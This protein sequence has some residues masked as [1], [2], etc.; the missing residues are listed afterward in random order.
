MQQ[1]HSF[2]FNKGDEE[3]SA[4][5]TK[6]RRSKS[7]L[8]NHDEDIANSQAIVHNNDADMVEQSN[9]FPQSAAK[10]YKSEIAND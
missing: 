3:L 8:V 10:V 7:N 5:K 2:S 1:D 6:S 9:L 4:S